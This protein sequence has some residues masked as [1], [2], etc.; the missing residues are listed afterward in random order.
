[1]PLLDRTGTPEAVPSK[2]SLVEQ[3]LAPFRRIA[4]HRRLLWRTTLVDLKSAYAG[5][6]L[7]TIWVGLGPLLML[8]LYA[9]IYAVIFRV[10]PTN[11]TVAE[12]VLYVFCGLV[13]F[14]AFASS[15][16]AGTLSLVSNRALLL[17]TVFPAELIPLRAVLVASASMPVGGVILLAGDLGLST[18]SVTAL[19]I[20]LVMVMQ[21]MFT[22]GLCWMLSLLALLIRDIQQLLYYITMLLLTITPIAYTPDM[23]PSQL[24][25]IMYLN[26]LY[27]F[28]ISFQ[29]LIIL[30]Q[31]P[32]LHVLIIGSGISLGFFIVG[33][34]VCTRAKQVFYD[35][36]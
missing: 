33:Y 31:I 35:Y 20:P 24:A 17:N 5:S 6:L 30:N 32:P 36:A 7:G 2:A 10:R 3:A 19:L 11:M 18:P 25:L 4:H 27:Y 14:L 12:Y 13:P 28:A 8:S 23:I 1:M 34:A 21:I 9:L 26:P 22:V 15:L 29:S 16:T